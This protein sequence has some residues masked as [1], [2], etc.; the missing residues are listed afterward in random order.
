MRCEPGQTN[1]VVTNLPSTHG[2]FMVSSP[3]RPGFD[4][5]SLP[6]NDDGS[7]GLVPL[8]FTI[9]FLSNSESALYVNNNGNVII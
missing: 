1:P 4:Q 6:P 2:F 7:T 9:N 3:I 5:Q 8:P